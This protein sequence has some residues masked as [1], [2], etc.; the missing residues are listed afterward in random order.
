VLLIPEW[1]PPKQVLYEVN[2]TER[3]LSDWAVVSGVPKTTLFHRVFKVGHR[4]P[5]SEGFEVVR[6]WHS[7]D[8]E[9]VE[10][11]SCD[12]DPLPHRCRS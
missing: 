10:G 9:K 3:T 5:V 4:H 1:E 2:G 7:R 6:K 11:D 8:F 12:V